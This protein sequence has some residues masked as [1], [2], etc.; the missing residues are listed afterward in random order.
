MHKRIYGLSM[1]IY[2]G[3]TDVYMGL[4]CRLT[5]DV[6]TYIV[7]MGLACRLSMDA[8]TYIWTWHVD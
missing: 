4:A 3:C 1:R 2:T 8:Q 6:Q 5:L 7:Y